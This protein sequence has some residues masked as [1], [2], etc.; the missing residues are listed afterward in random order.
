[1]KPSQ[2]LRVFSFIVLSLLLHI[3]IF[4][5]LWSEKKIVAGNVVVSVLDKGSRKDAPSA[6]HTTNNSSEKFNQLQNGDEA[7]SDIQ[8][9]EMST[10]DNA[11]G[12]G[13]PSLGVGDTAGNSLASSALGIRAEYPRLSRV[14]KESGRVQIAIQKADGIDPVKVLI[15]QSSGFSRLDQS[16]LAATRKALS[17]GILKTYLDSKSNMQ[18]EYIFELSLAAE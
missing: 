16:A 11:Q 5:P 12:A 7:R 1:V 10:R 3:F 9:N 8:N 4:Y 14:L 18:I 2:A 17:D 13:K 6:S 15:Q